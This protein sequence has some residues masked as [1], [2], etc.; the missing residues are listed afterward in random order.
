VLFGAV[1]LA[2]ICAVPLVARQATR[3]DLSRETPGKPPSMFDTIMGVWSIVQVDRDKVIKVDGAAWKA[4]Q[5]TPTQLL[6]DSARRMYGTTNEE[7]MDNAKQFTVY[8]VAV[9]KSVPSFSNGTISVN[10][11]TIGGD[12]DRASGI[13]FNL[14]PNG[15]WLGLRYNEMEHN[16][17]L[18]EFH[19][20]VR[21]S[22]I[23]PRHQLLTDPAEHDKWH[24][25]KVEVKGAAI[26]GYLDGANVL[27]WT[28]GSEPGPGRGGRAP[29]PDLFPANNPV[30]RPPVEGKVGLWAKSDTTSYFKDYVVTPAK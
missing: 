22:V 30:L 25:L 11:K 27:E 24:E 17:V 8:P 18:W 13:L 26:T 6:L 12:A 4:S 23:R 19:N 10:F 15:D 28:L 5:D 20:G 21:R 1:A 29:H 9:L 14:K 16:V 3:V 2:A 7:L